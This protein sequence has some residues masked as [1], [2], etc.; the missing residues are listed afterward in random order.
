M[1]LKPVTGDAVD[2]L[3]WLDKVARPQLVETGLRLAL[4]VR[5]EGG[6]VVIEGWTAT[7]W[8]NGK[9]TPGRWKAKA[10]VTRHFAQASSNMNP[11]LLPNRDDLLARAERAGW[12]GEDDTPLGHRPLS[13]LLRP[14]DASP[15]VVDGDIAGNVLFSPGHPP[16]VID[17]SL[18]ARPVEWFVAVLAI[19]AVCFQ[20]APSR[21]W[22]PSAPTLPS[23]STSLFE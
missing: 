13:P 23:R 11:R 2:T 9:P 12:A 18:Y 6:A 20:N 19:D 21:S 3:I 17:L 5:S 22:T 15:A 4:A 16:A 1:V 14:V 7:S 10:E 8:L